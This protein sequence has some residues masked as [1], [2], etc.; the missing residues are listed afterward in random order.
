[1]STLADLQQFH[2]LRPHFLWLLLPAALT[3]WGLARTVLSSGQ[4]QKIIDADLL[5]HLLLRGG[6]RRPWLFALIFTLFAGMIVALAG[7]TWRKLPTPV[8]SSQDALVILLDLSPS[9][10]AT[11]LSPD[12]LTRA[13]LKV[14]DILRQRKD[15]L[16]ALVAYGGEAHVVTPLTEDTATI[17][18]L[19]P[20]LSPA[21]M[22]VPGSN[23]EM[24]VE[25]GIRLLK[26]GA[27][28]RGQLLAVTD[29][30]DEM[31]VDTVAKLV[32]GARVELSILAVGS[33]EGSPIPRGNGSG[34]I[35][36][37]N[38]SIIIANFDARELARLARGSGG[39]FARISVDDS[40]IVRLLPDTEAPEQAQLTE[41]EFDQWREEGPWL[42]LLLL[43]LAALLFRRGALACTLPF[44]LLLLP[45]KQAQ[46]FEWRDLWQREDQQARELLEE[47][48]PEQAAETF[49]S[50]QWRGTANYRAGNYPAAEQDFARSSDAE[51]L[52]NLG[53][54]LTQQGLY[55]EAIAAYDE[56]LKEQPQF[57]DARHNRAIAEKLK[58]LQ[59]K[60]QQQSQQDQQQSGE[61]QQQQSGDK[62]QQQNQDQ[63]QQQSQQ[64]AGSQSEP[65]GSESED[66]S[67]QQPQNGEQQ[68]QEQQKPG[69]KQ[70][71]EDQQQGEQQRAGA[72]E[73]PLDPE[74]QQALDQWLRQI[75]DDPAGLMREKFKYES[76]QRRRAYRSGEWR[77]PENGATQRW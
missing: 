54:S 75:P 20:A 34:F 66:S 22:P 50:P 24:A 33:G 15:G 58:K 44:A 2:F 5:P 45:A 43:P 62:Q 76:L 29:G 56:A 11:D 19:V 51:G 60:Q 70:Q 32:A 64:N 26:D 25:T 46:A 12:R 39:R 23:I 35:T 4:L 8:Y 6:A 36:D 40:D 52:Y 48:Q 61:Q 9:M 65:S 77:P 63:Q 31:A 30:I 1:M 72:E 73:S 10:M 69:E 13:R 47:G 27:A 59:E 74:T 37:S 3:C 14:L 57:A 21:I 55:N 16:T 38:G 67:A 53:N 68:E 49:E 28:G 42:V 71:G 18:N 41:R 17:A 7:P